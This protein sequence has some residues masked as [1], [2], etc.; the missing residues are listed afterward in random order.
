MGKIRNRLAAT[1]PISR[2][3]HGEGTWSRADPNLPYTWTYP[4]VI[5]HLPA[6]ESGGLPCSDRAYSGLTPYSY[7]A[8]S[9][10]RP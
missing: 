1:K 10:L 6:A 8:Y 5:L 3:A 2:L 4:I 9:G 7:R